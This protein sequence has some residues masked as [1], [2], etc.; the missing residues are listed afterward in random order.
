[1][2][3]DDRPGTVGW[4]RERLKQFPATAYVE[5]PGWCRVCGKEAT[6][7]IFGTTV[8]PNVIDRQSVVILLPPDL[9]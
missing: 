5:I 1:M 4:L 6:G 2:S 7:P 8:V 3:D 9:P